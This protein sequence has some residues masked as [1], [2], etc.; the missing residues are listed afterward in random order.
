MKE[1]RKENLLGL[2]NNLNLLGKRPEKQTFLNG[3]ASVYREIVPFPRRDKP[4]SQR[5]HTHAH[6]T[7]L[8][9]RVVCL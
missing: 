7:F 2:E 3:E 4:E 8:I 9:V 6:E 5:L 1:V